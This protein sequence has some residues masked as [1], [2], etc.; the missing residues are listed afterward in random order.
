M[1][2]AK[3]AKNEKFLLTFG[4]KESIILIRKRQERKIKK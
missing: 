4:Y 1:T 2:T 3:P